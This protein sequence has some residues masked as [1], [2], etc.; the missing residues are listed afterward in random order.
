MQLKFAVLGCGDSLYANNYNVAAKT[1]RARLGQ[2]GAQE[3]CPMGACAC[4]VSLSIIADVVMVQ[5]QA[6][7]TCRALTMARQ[8]QTSKRGS[9][10]YELRGGGLA[11]WAHSVCFV[12]QTVVAVVSG[13]S[14]SAP[15]TSASASAVDANADDEYDVVDDEEETKGTQ[16]CWSVHVWVVCTSASLNS[17][18]SMGDRTSLCWT[19]RIWAACCPRA[20]LLQVAWGQHH[21]RRRQRRR[22]QARR[23]TRQMTHG[24][25]DPR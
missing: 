21:H 25:Q 10:Y 2:M 6:M 17:V 5:A 3:M 16:V 23:W 22:R 15:P 18:R 13:N 20:A 24:R 4:G 14:A 12:I 7:R 19:W 11:L 8:R 9:R 1:L